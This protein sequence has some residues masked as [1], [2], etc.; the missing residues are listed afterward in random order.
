MFLAYANFG[1][2]KCLV[3][4]VFL[5]LHVWTMLSALA[6]FGILSALSHT[7]LQGF[8]A[9]FFFFFEKLSVYVLFS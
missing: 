5:M 8:P 6:K 4:A 9:W 1:T 3:Y 7:V 2:A